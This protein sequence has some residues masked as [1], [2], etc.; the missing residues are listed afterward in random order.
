[1]LAFLRNAVEAAEAIRPPT[2]TVKA[3]A[4]RGLC[5]ADGTLTEPGRVLSISVLPLAKQCQIL[6][7]PVDE[8]RVDRAKSSPERALMDA[9][10]A[11]GTPCC[12]TEGGIVLV[13]L[14]SLC[15]ERLFRLGAAKWG[16]AN[17]IVTAMGKTRTPVQ[18]MM[19]SSVIVYQEF[20]RTNVGLEDDLLRDIA[21]V[22]VPE[23]MKNFEV[24]QSWQLTESWYP[25][26]YVG[27]T[28]GL[29]QLVLETLPRASLVEIA[30]LFFSDPHAYAK[31]WPDLTLVESG[32]VRFIEVKTGDCLDPSQII[33]IG[34]MRAAAGLSVTI[35]RLVA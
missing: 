17:Y 29:V 22:S 13:A 21:S 9:Y 8:C 4:A 15:F 19:Y 18:S 11:A 23:A 34:E 28:P 12:F 20:L 35:T 14:Y 6:G 16:D 27:M 30:R 32:E 24:L 7:V 3:L 31:G 33:T 2:R 1:M 10:I 26:S 5:L 25:H